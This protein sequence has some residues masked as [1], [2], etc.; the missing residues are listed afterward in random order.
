[1][2][3]L[4]NSSRIP[5]LDEPLIPLEN[6]IMNTGTIRNVRR[7]MLTLVIAALVALSAAYAPVFLDEMAGTSMTAAV[8]ACAGTTGGC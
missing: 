1:M 8:S 6:I 4:P 2:H 5:K 3:V 7:H